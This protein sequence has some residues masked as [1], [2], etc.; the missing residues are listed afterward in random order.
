MRSA[1]SCQ[2]A[3]TTPRIGNYILI[4]AYDHLKD[5]QLAELSVAA[6]ECV[7]AAKYRTHD[8]DEC[9]FVPKPSILRS[10]AH[11]EPLTNSPIIPSFMAPMGERQTSPETIKTTGRFVVNETIPGAE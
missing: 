2:Q 9:A 5:D 6:I 10:N 3:E 1:L 11:T 4:A 8:A 7:P